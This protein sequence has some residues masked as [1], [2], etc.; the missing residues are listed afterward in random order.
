MIAAQRIVGATLGIVFGF[1]LVWSG[2]I[3][4]DVIRGALLFEDSYLYFFMGSAVGTA[5]LGLALVRR[6]RPRAV[7]TGGRV[8]WSSEPVERRHLTGA[9]MFGIGWG[10]TA[11]CPGPLAAQLGQGIAWSLPV[12]AGVVVGVRLHQRQGRAETE[13]A[14]ERFGRQPTAGVTGERYVR[15]RPAGHSAGSA[16]NA[17][18]G[19]R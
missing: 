2:M 19:R 16:G 14:A 4:P 7:L 13:P 15:R 9:L 8:Q 12:L 18:T 3:S 17:A 1:V 5:A 11:V 6:L 10:I